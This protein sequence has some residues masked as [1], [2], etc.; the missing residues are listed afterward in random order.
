MTALRIGIDFDNTLAGYDHVFAAAARDAGLMPAGFTGTKT[1]VRERMRCLPDGEKEWMELQGQVYGA[2]MAKAE[3]IDG[4]GA[5]LT[6]CRDRG[7]PVR[8]VSHKTTYGHFDPQRVNL[9]EAAM[10]W[11]TQKG[12]FSADGFGLAPENVSF[13]LTRADKVARIA[14]LGVSHFIDDLEDV[15]LEP[16]F[17]REVKAYLLATG[18][19]PLPRGPFKA[20]RRWQDIAE[21]ILGGAG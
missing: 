19:G 3:M 2:R 16:H 20:L 15:F 4:A 9:R 17:P 10:A 13:E 1:D 21:D 18:T 11:M 14:S 8:I 12:F 7:I 6:A 5:F